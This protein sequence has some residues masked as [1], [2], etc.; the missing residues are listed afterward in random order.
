MVAG[1]LFISVGSLALALAQEW[2]TSGGFRTSRYLSVWVLAA[3][4]AGAFSMRS[5][6][7]RLDD[8]IM[9][10]GPLALTLAT[11]AAALPALALWAGAVQ[12]R[13]KKL[14]SRPWRHRFVALA[15]VHATVLFVGSL[16][17]YWIVGL[18]W[19]SQVH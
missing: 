19:L 1:I 12:A 16:V 6:K 4:L 9:R 17:A 11:L 15:R 13:S 3:V 14:A 5:F 2:A 8:P 18:V 10:D 7:L